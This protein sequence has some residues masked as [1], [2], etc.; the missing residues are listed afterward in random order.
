MLKL[1]SKHSQC[2][3]FSLC[4]GLFGRCTVGKGTRNVQH[5]GT[6]AAV[7]FL[8][9]FNRKDHK[10]LFGTILPFRGTDSNRVAV[11]SWW[12]AHN[13]LPF[14][15]K[16]REYTCGAVRRMA[17]AFSFRERASRCQHKT[18]T[19]R[20]A[21]LAFGTRVLRSGTGDKD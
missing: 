6:P 18:P 11:R 14:S 3:C 7:F 15:R 20:T 1:V 4:L 12:C 19:A 9:E 10:N 16:P 5:F 2:D 21:P 17:P 13:G 8:V